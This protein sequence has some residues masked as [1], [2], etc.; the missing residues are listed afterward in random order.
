MISRKRWTYRLQ[1]LWATPNETPII[2]L[3]NQKSGTSAIA[4]LL[5]DHGALSKTIDI[6]PL[7]LPDS[8]AILRGERA[9]ADVVRQHPAYFARDLFKEP[10]MT[11]FA[12]AVVDR[13]PQATYV[14]VVRD[15]RDNIRSLLDSRDLPGDRDDLTPADW[16][17]DAA[18]RH[19]ADPALWGGDDTNYVGVLAHRWNRAVRAYFAHADRMHRVRY[20]TFMDD[21]HACIAALAHTIGVPHRRD[22]RDR[23]D[24]AYQPRG[25]R[26]VD[27]AT[28][29]G[30]ANLQRIE[31]ICRDGMQRLGYAPDPSDDTSTHPP[32]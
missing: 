14:F 10:M 5:A 6:P 31:R 26:A 27:W 16:P 3:G 7:W 18:H 21:K 20:E 22:I 28:F 15:P 23:L 4:H 8:A 17:D 30:T 24:R 9:F 11:F 32:S 25:N 2:V 19:V 12:D 1:N 29:F 13:F